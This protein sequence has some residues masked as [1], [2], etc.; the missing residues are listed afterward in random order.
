[1]SSRE[2]EREGIRHLDEA[3]EDRGLFDSSEVCARPD[4][5]VPGFSRLIR[6]DEGR[7][8]EPPRIALG[9]K[10]IDASCRSDIALDARSRDVTASGFRPTMQSSR[11]GAAA[12]YGGSVT[13]VEAKR[14]ARECS[15]SH[16]TLPPKAGSARQAPNGP[17]HFRETSARVAFDARATPFAEPPRVVC[18][19]SGVRFDSAPDGRDNRAYDVDCWAGD[20]TA[21]GCTARMHTQPGC[22]FA[23]GAACL[24]AFPKG[25]R[26][27]AAGVFKTGPSYRHPDP[28]HSGRVS[29]ERGAFV[30]RPV[31]LAGLT[32]FHL[33]T[34]K[35]LRVRVD[36]TDV[37][38]D[39][40][41]WHLRTWGDQHLSWA[42]ASY[43]AMDF[44]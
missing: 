2:H 26:H 20:V 17:A 30:R 31:V 38:L 15:I 16:A 5:P 35:D 7:Y 4:Q 19:L 29:F 22:R 36:V 37:S 12:L 33:Q 41:T 34:G 25:K 21:R 18:W 3:G 13:W 28:Q 42:C 40:F 10:A 23:G 27:V 24:V 11:P 1:M 32:G 9:F 8:H 6:F 44:D 43:I 14:L 39:G